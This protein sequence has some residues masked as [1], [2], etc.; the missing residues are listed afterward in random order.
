MCDLAA[1]G[2]FGLPRFELGTDCL[3][4]FPHSCGTLSGAWRRVDELFK[5]DES[6]RSE[7][8]AHFAEKWLELGEDH[9][10]LAIRFIEK[11]GTDCSVVDERCCHVPV[12]HDHP[13][14][15]AVLAE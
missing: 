11:V 6:L 12:A 15:P 8:C 14:M 1:T 9:E 3:H 7:T 4:T 5:I 10:M 13:Q 2:S